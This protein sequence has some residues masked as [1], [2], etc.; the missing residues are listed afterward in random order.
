MAARP[1]RLAEQPNANR[2]CQSRSSR[3]RR[4][5]PRFRTDPPT[6]APRQRE[7]RQP[8]ARRSPQARTRSRPTDGRFARRKV[9]DPNETRPRARSREPC[10]RAAQPDP[11]RAPRG[12]LPL[13]SS[14]FRRSGSG[15]T[16]SPDTGSNPVWALGH[17]TLE[18]L[19]SGARAP[20]LALWSV[21]T[22]SSPQTPTV[23]MR[24]AG[25]P[26]RV[27]RGR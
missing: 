9:P 8:H 19:Q 14:S 15:T 4:H 22:S 7:Q 3:H 21:V 24:Q 10:R 5:T 27:I 17:L 16:F 6:T 25:R 12:F 11:S 2:S 20:S 18:D 1:S 23:T 26:P 13:S